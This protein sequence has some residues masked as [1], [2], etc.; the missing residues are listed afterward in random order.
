MLQRLREEYP[1]R[2]NRELSRDLG[3]SVRSLIRKARE[4]GVRKED[5]FIEKRMAE[6]EKMANSAA[7]KSKRPN[8]KGRHLNPAGEFKP[9]HKESA[10]TK[11]RRIAA[12]KDTAYREKVR[13]KYGLPRKTK[14]PVKDSL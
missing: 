6:I 10:E 5:R 4:L 11:R 14:W 13:L 2:Y 9:G 7:K 12:L 1:V 8:M 3:V